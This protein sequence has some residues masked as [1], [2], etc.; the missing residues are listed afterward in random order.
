M[1]FDNDA[2]R[3][4]YDKAA[5]IPIFWYFDA[6]FS[7]TTENSIYR[8]KAIASLRLGASSVVLDAACGTGLN[9]KILESY[10]GRN[11]RL[12]GVDL[13]P[14]VLD[15]AERKIRKRNW[16]NIELVNAS[17][18]DYMPGIL[19]D[20]VLCTFALTIVPDYKAA[21]DK[22]FDLLKPQG[23]FAMI[24]MRDS[25]HMPYKLANPI[26]EWTCGLTGIELQRDVLAYIESK[27]NDFDYEEC[28]GGFYYI[29][30]VSKSCLTS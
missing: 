1:Q 29:L 11:G 12:I 24:G 10:L 19:F 6:L 27:C 9:F 17:I 26:W 30:C 4:M 13:S 14:G 16:K 2:I 25:S 22:M 23:R 5:K 20:A 3:A 15:A 21:I 7:R 8:K 18:S 28:F